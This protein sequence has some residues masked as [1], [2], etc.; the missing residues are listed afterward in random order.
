VDQLTASRALADFFEQA[1]AG[2]SADEGGAA[3][4]AKNVSNWILRDLLRALKELGLEVEDSK[5]TPPML[6]SL[7]DL[8]DAGRLT[9]K[10]AQEIFQELV[11][12][13]G[14]P[15]A[16]MGERSLEAISDTGQLETAVDQVLE[17]NP[18]VVESF[19]GGDSKSINFLMGK[20]MKK[21]QGKADPPQ[22]RE[23]LIRK[24]E[25]S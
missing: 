23:L 14:D 12:R 16:L 5:I 4:A 2:S 11:E 1:V 8:V 3:A 6:A 22:V 10:N 24:L 20:V 9:V 19:R 25:P 21:L 17:A 15:E 18:Q 13:G 7:I